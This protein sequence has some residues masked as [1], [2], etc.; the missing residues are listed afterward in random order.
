MAE[1]LHGEVGAV[2]EQIA[3]F[4]VQNLEWEGTEQEL[5][6]PDDPVELPFVLDSADLLELAGYLEDAFGIMIADEE[7]VAD[8]F[9]T[10]RHLATL[11]VDKLADV[12]AA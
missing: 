10:V 4:I 1:N 7:L 5:L 6:A 9:V 2:S 11:I 12:G 8:N 3:A